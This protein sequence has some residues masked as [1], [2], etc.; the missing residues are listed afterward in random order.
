VDFPVLHTQR[1]HLLK[2]DPD[3]RPFIFEGLSHPHVISFYGV[4]Y[5][6]LEATSAQMDWYRQMEKDETGLAWKVVERNTGTSCGVISVYFFKR[7][8]RKAELG[9]WFLPSFWGKGYA[10]EALQPVIRYWQQE[11][12][13]HRLEAYVE[14]G[15]DSSRRLLI[16]NG[17][18]EEGLMKDCEIKNG[19][20]IS[21]YV[22]ALIS[23][24]PAIAS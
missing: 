7:E 15:N 6:S 3:D 14:A 23:E 8:H 4:R 17:F 13:L 22:Y 24:P 5:E 2:I 21:L 10:S 16:K 19:H 12:S 1:L 20:F 9:F 11:Q 18:A